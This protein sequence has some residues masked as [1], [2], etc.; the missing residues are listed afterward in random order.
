MK[1][2]VATTGFIY[3]YHISISQNDVVNLAE[4]FSRNSEKISVEVNNFILEGLEDLKIHS[5][6]LSLGMTLRIDSVKIIFNKDRIYVF[7]DINESALANSIVA[8]IKEFEKHFSFLLNSFFYFVVIASI[9]CFSAQVGLTLL[10][11]NLAGRNTANMDGYIY[12]GWFDKFFHADLFDKIP[13]IV[14]F[15]VIANIILNARKQYSFCQIT[16]S[17]TKKSSYEFNFWAINSF[18]WVIT[19]LAAPL[20]V[21]YLANRFGWGK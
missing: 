21:T 12:T 14:I 8:K 5:H 18:F 20:F 19:S 9:I 2:I 1:E 3:I 15:L 10:V 7:Y 11:Q 6:M 17:K 13:G 16:S 4:T